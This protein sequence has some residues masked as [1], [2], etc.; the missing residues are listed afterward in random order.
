MFDKT[1]LNCPE[2][3]ELE[4]TKTIAMK[5]LQEGV[6]CGVIARCTGLSKEE[7]M[8]LDKKHKCNH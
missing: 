3:L 2:K 1:T 5:M 6:C 7:V 8:N 4:T